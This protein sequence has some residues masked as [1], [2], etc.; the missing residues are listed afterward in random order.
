VRTIRVNDTR[1]GS[2]GTVPC[3]RRWTVVVWV[4]L[5]VKKVGSGASKFSG[6]SYRFSNHNSSKFRKRQLALLGG[7]TRLHGYKRGLF[8]QSRPNCIQKEWIMRTSQLIG[9]QHKGF[10][11]VSSEQEIFDGY[12][13]RLTRWGCPKC[14][15]YEKRVFSSRAISKELDAYMICRFAAEP[16]DLIGEATAC[17]KDCKPQLRKGKGKSGRGRL[18]YVHRT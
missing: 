11:G 14:N 6:T 4:R 5:C 3:P 10:L 8:A 18:H 9:D 15:F 17:P 2:G 1:L 13:Q 7:K 16:V 12:E